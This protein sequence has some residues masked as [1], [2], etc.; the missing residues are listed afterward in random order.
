MNASRCW[1]V[2]EFVPEGLDPE[3]LEARWHDRQLRTRSRFSKWKEK[4][5]RKDKNIRPEHWRIIRPSGD[6]WEDVRRRDR[7]VLSEAME[8]VRN[9][10][11]SFPG[12][13]LRVRNL[14]DDHVI[15]GAILC[16][17]IPVV[18]PN[19]MGAN[20]AQAFNNGFSGGV[21][22]LKN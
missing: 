19:T 9:L 6:R 22:H 8:A 2:E 4:L 21:H 17:D 13:T 14:R 5:R 18:Q 15:L 1:I 12:L 20:S 16:A 7:M 10:H 11:R 3:G